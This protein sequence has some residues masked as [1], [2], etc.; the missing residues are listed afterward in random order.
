MC[1]LCM[2]C[3]FFIREKMASSLTAIFGPT[4]FGGWSYKLISVHPSIR[5]SF[6]LCDSPCDVFWP[7]LQK[8]SM[9]LPNFCMSLE[10]SRA[11]RLSQ[12]VFLKNS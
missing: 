8:G 10:D 9:D 6:C 7:L 1:V 5:R 3:T 12:M 11:Q 4:D 2:C